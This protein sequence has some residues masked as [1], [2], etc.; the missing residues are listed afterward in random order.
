MADPALLD[1]IAHG[2]FASTDTK[3]NAGAA[4]GME[5]LTSVRSQ[6]ALPLVAIGGIDEG[7]AADAIKAGADGISVISA[8]MAS[9]D[10]KAASA[11]L[12]LVVDKALA[13]RKERAA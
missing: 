12:K 13:D 5:G 7:N 8:I 10:P 9:S 4:V 11:K 2:P 3:Q 1:Y 6:S